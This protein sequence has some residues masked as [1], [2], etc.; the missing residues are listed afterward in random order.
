LYFE[1]FIVSLLRLDRDVLY[2]VG[3]LTSFLAAL[4]LSF[5]WVRSVSFAPAYDGANV[6]NVVNIPDHQL[7]PG[8]IC[9]VALFC[10]GEIRC[11]FKIA[12]CSS[13]LHFPVAVLNLTGN[14]GRWQTSTRGIFVGY[15]AAGLPL[16]NVSSE[17]LHEAGQSIARMS[18]DILKQIVTDSDSRLLFYFLILNLGN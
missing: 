14:G 4:V 3:S 2:R 11:I 18:K 13:Y 15:S 12:T 6:V 7:S 16:Y 1:L 10:F 8:V 17:Y 5:F 9:A